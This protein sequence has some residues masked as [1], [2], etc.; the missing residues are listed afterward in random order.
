MCKIVFP[1]PCLL[2]TGCFFNSIVCILFTRK[3]EN[4]IRIVL[5]KADMMTHQQLMRVYGALMWSLARILQNPEVTV[6]LIRTDLHS[7][8]S[9]GE[10][11]LC[12]QLL[13]SASAVCWQQRVV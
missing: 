11:D 6:E 13:E 9:A 10:Q 12:W 4:K 5:N 2:M 3:N 1:Q 8:S 7:S